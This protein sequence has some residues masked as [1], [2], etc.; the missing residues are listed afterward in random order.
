[1]V[2]SEMAP[3]AK[4][5]GLADVI[6]ALPRAL[7]RLGHHVT[8][9]LPRYRGIEA[10]TLRDRLLLPLVDT[11]LEVGFWEQSVAPNVRAVFVEAAALYE[12]DGLYGVGSDD[13]ADNPRRFACLA[14]A[15][16]EFAARQP[17]PPDVVHA[18]DWQGG[19]VPVYLRA[20]ADRWPGLAG[21]PT[22]FTIHNLAYQGLCGRDWLPR[23][24][25]DAGLLHVNGLEYWGQVSLLKGGINFCDAVTT[26]SP[27]YA[28][29]IQMP[30]L[31]FGFDGVLARRSPDLT[32]ILNGIDTDEWSPARDPH[33]PVPYDATTV[34]AGKRAAKSQLLR[35]FGLPDDEAA[36]ARPVVGLISRMVDQKGLDILSALGDD[37]TR[38]GATFVVL[39]T[40]ETRYQDFW[41]SLAARFREAVSVRIGFD[42]GLA[43]LIE[44]GADLFLMPSRFEPCG[45]NQMYSLRYGTVPIVR[46]TGGLGDTVVDYQ[47]G[48][49]GSTGFTFTGYAPE[50]LRAALVR[51][52]E[53][54]GKPRVWKALQRRGMRQDFSW[55]ASAGA[56]VKLYERVTNEGRTH[57]L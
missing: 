56:Y 32:G 27:T 53:A 30:D 12:R 16:L 54:F 19:L 4:T 15:A 6:G 10:G 22:V 36:L 18:H 48:R 55:D 29:E 52:L 11:P 25:L 24:G 43:H 33:L 51:A 39:G 42:E 21:C 49:A 9:V 41:T 1:M 17:A 20:R 35:A 40:G 23:L 8:V 28:R 46:A 31:G 7:G 37:L 38:L 2:A 14:L 5:G 3:F 45:L 13:Y 26:V 44:G 57:G 34:T 47:T 50:A